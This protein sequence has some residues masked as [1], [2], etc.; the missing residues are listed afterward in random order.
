MSDLPRAY[1]VPAETWTGP[2]EDP[3]PVRRRMTG[4]LGWALYYVALAV[5]AIAFPAVFPWVLGVIGACLAVHA[6]V[7]VARAIRA[8]RTA[9]ANVG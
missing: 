7:V 8:R 2:D 6:V 4:T 3:R 9:R 1:P 5:V